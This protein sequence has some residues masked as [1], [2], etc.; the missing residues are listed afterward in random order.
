MSVGEKGPFWSVLSSAGT[1]GHGSVP[2]GADNAIEPIVAGL[3]GLFSTDMPVLISDE[4]VAFVETAGIRPPLRDDLLDPDRVDR[5][6]ERLA[7]E[8]PRFAA[9]VHACTHM[10]VSPNVIDAGSKA[11]MVAD[12]AQ[13]QVDVR[14]LPGQTR[15]DVD[16]HLR[17]SMGSASDRIEIE[18]VADHEANSSPLT[19]PLW[20][21]VVDSIEALTGSRRVVPTMMPATTDARFFRDRGVVSYGVGLFDDSVSFPDF[22]SMFHGHDER[23]SL[24]SLRLTT[25]L[26]EEILLRW[27][28]S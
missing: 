12:R 13:A 9:Y 23:I 6:I 14:A 16:L 25:A 24:E 10:T 20:E 2:F 5:A 22:L 3:S 1:P 15:R 8:D 28:G 21:T 27:S 18:P 26:V 7:E 19:N 4:W 17:K 11:N